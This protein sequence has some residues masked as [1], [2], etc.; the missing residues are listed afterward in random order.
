MR[1][2][3]GGVSMAELGDRHVGFIGLGAMGLP[4]ALNLVRAGLTVRGHDIAEAARDRL[5]E[6]GGQAVTTPAEAATDAGLLVLVVATAAQAE[7]VLFG[8]GAAADALPK[9]ATVVLHSTV[10]PAFARQLGE[11]LAAAGHPLLDA[12]ISGGRVGAEAASLTV[13]AS[14]SAAAIGNGKRSSWPVSST[15]PRSLTKISTA[16][17]GV[18]SRLRICGTRLV[19]I[20]ELPALFE[21][22]S[23]S[24]RAS[25]P[26]RTPSAMASL[27]AAMW[28]PA[29][30]WL[31]ILTV[32]PMPGASPSR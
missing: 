19:N 12:P 5:A 8:E 30:C 26:A 22:T 18:K 2:D 29:R 13:M 23:N 16:E 25:A 1:G 4:M 24:V 14:G 10:P 17:R 6:G 21:I 31:I 28:T 7:A 32:E 20:H 27:A 3:S 9:G 15:M 11:R